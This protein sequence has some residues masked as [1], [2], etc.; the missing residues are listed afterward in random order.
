M[1]RFPRHII[2]RIL[3]AIYLVIVISPLAPLAMES[4]T[5]AHAITGQCTGDCTTCGCSPERTALHTCCC[6][7]NRLTAEQQHHK[8]EE[9]HNIRCTDKLPDAKTT[10][11]RH[12]PCGNDKQPDL[13][14]AERLELLPYQFNGGTPPAEAGQLSHNVLV[15]FTTRCI[16]PPDPPPKP[17]MLS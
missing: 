6:W 13:W 3:A 10:L 15:R 5:I 16:E 8:H 12:C 17:S 4:V 7:Q 1:K 9:L 11:S 2:A 14:D